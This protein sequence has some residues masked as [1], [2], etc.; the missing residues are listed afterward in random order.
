[1]RIVLI[2]TLQDEDIKKK[3][4][5]KRIKQLKRERKENEI[6]ESGK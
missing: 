6:L 3:N 5:D 1:M 2:Y 4:L